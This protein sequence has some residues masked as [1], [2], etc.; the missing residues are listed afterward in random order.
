MFGR[1]NNRYY[2]SSYGGGSYGYPPYVSAAEKK[3]RNE[4]AIATLRKKNPDIAPVIVTGRK[5]ARNWW[6][7]A[8][9]SNLERYADYANRIDRGKSYLRSGAVLNLQIQAGVV[10]A[11]VQGTRKA[12]YKVDVMVDPLKDADWERLRAACGDRLSSMQTLLTGRFPEDL[13]DVLT[14]KGKGLFPAPKEIHIHCSCPD[15]AVLCKHAAAVLY[16]IGARFDEAPAL[17]FALRG[18][19][20]EELVKTAVQEQVDS[21]IEK[22]EKRSRR[23]LVATPASLQKSVEGMGS[24][25]AR[26]STT[27]KRPA[28]HTNSTGTKSENRAQDLSA[29]FG[30]DLSAP[31]QRNTGRVAKASVQVQPEAGSTGETFPLVQAVAPK[32]RGRPRKQPLVEVTGDALATPAQGVAPKKRGRPRKNPL[33]EVTTETLAT[34]AQA[35]APKKRGRPRKQ[36]VTVMT[37]ESVTVAPPTIVP[38]R[39]GRPKK[40]NK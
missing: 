34:P 29:L 16:G 6:G 15:Y 40:Q 33:V 1:Q 9:N 13:A 3:E 26:A 21:L 24:E 23:A 10:H 25:K 18:Q 11:L 38:K 4:R 22:S 12:P 37:E 31:V 8:W 28:V 19:S 36:P 20:M 30:I 2:H 7:I 35:V 27:S 14:T 5:L 17:F 39:R 32:K